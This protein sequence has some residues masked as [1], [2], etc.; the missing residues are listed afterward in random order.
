MTERTMQPSKW[1]VF[2]FDTMATDLKDEIYCTGFEPTEQQIQGIAD[3]VEGLHLL[4]YRP[5][6]IC[7]FVTWKDKLFWVDVRLTYLDETLF[8]DG[9]EQDLN[10][11]LRRME[12]KVRYR[13]PQSLN[14]YW[15]PGALPSNLN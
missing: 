9:Q 12:G 14:S 5:S 13:V 11:L 6:P 8:F 10:T 7:L 3:F 2:G 1:G 4:I 15:D